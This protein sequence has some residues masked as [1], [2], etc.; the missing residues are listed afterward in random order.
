MTRNERKESSDHHSVIS[1]MAVRNASAV[2][3]VTYFYASS[4][5]ENCLY[6]LLI[7]YMPF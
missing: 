4:D 5:P 1:K 3:R 6:S 2:V 7:Q